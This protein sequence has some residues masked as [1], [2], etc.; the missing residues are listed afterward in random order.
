MMTEPRKGKRLSVDYIKSR[1]AETEF[2]MKEHFGQKGMFC[3]FKLDN[4]FVVYGNKPSMAIDPEN[5]DEE[6]GKQYSYNNTFEQLWQLFAFG[7]LER[8]AV[9]DQFGTPFDLDSVVH[10]L[11][12]R[13]LR[14]EGLR[15]I[16]FPSEMVFLH[17]P[18]GEKFSVRSVDAGEDLTDKILKELRTK[19]G[20]GYAT[21][22]NILQI[23]KVCHEA[24]RA[25]CQ[26]IGDDSQVPWEQAPD[27]QK[28]SAVKGVEFHLS[29]DHG[30][31]ASHQSWYD[32]KKADGWIYGPVKDVEKKEHPCMVAYSQLPKEQQAKDYIFRAVVHSFK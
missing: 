1:I 10:L 9:L 27:W 12:V 19:F 15:G 3:H 30:P 4:G 25:Y 14:E 8:Q 28:E 7:L 11:D 16:E 5:F 26:A 31:S 18:T 32:E 22:P 23:A 17:K 21:N 13:R 24:N 6:M 2:E 29:G 20:I